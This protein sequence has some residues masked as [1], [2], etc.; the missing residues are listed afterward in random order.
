MGGVEI[1]CPRSLGCA[2]DVESQARCWRGGYSGQLVQHDEAVGCVRRAAATGALPGRGEV[3]SLAWAGSWRRCGTSMPALPWSTPPGDQ[4]ATAWLPSGQVTTQRPSSF[5]TQGRVLV[6]EGC[7]QAASRSPGAQPP[8][9]PVSGMDPPRAPW[10]GVDFP[11]WGQEGRHARGDRGRHAV[12]RGVP[13]G[14]L[15]QDPGCGRGPRWGSQDTFHRRGVMCG[16]ANSAWQTVAN[17]DSSR[18]RPCQSMRC[19]NNGSVDQRLMAG[20]FSY[21]CSTK[22]R[23]R[24]GSSVFHPGGWRRMDYDEEQPPPVGE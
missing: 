21:R 11:R 17:H 15:A 10:W 16:H 8:C 12:Q 4:S 2:R 20:Q 24:R 19:R 6:G 23:I 13:P 7:A 14:P 1:P 18:G 22:T 5:L 3:R 9:L